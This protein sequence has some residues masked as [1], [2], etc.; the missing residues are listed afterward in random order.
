MR[1]ASILAILIL[2]L[3]F[4]VPASAQEAVTINTM[5]IDIWPEYDRP[6]VLV[7]YRFSLAASTPLPEKM[8]LRIP[9]A[10]GEPYNVAFVDVTESG[11]TELFN[12][13]YTTE[14]QGDWLVVSFNAPSP[15]IQLEYYDPGLLRSGTTREYQYTWPADYTVQS[16]AVQVQQPVNA[17]DMQIEPDMGTGEV[18]QD[19]LTYYNALFGQVETGE[20]FNLTL[21]YEKPD[22]ILSKSFEAVFPV[23]TVEV[24]QPISFDSV[25]PWILGGVGVLLVVGAAIWYFMPNR[26]PAVPRKRHSGAGSQEQSETG[27]VFCNN[28][29]TRARNGDIFC[30][31]CGTKLRK[32]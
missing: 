3:L 11:E 12:L 7:I 8:S 1:R 29:G 25:L 31:T 22:D 17:S 20:Q 13:E 21:R 14:Q 28:C 10:S 2:S 32:S 16:M 9:S 4:P 27:D 15:D 24:S 5:H 19:G 26:Q 6:D 18:F 30:H 23:E